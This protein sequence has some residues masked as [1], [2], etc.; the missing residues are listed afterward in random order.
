MAIWLQLVPR[1]AR[2][3]RIQS[4]RTGFAVG[5]G[6]LDPKS[7]IE[8]GLDRTSPRSSQKR[9]PVAASGRAQGRHRPFHGDAG[10]SDDQNRPAHASRQHHKGKL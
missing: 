4:A 1:L 7:G 10:D 8:C 3:Q 6:R 9:L 5:R 2:F